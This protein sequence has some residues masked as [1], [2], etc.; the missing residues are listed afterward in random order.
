MKGLLRAPKPPAGAPP[1]API[2]TRDAAAKAESEKPGKTSDRGGDK[3]V[4]A[5][6]LPHDRWGQ[7][8][9]N[10]TV[11]EDFFDAHANGDSISAEAI[12]RN[13][14]SR[15]IKRS[16]LIFS[17]TNGN[18]RFE[19]REP[20]GRAR[21][22]G[23]PIIL[24]QELDL[25]QFRYAYVFPDDTGYRVLRREI[26]RRSGVGVSM[27]ADTKRVYINVGELR[28]VWAGCPLLKAESNAGASAGS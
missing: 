2:D 25:R 15:G 14:D 3:R 27:K 9:F 12:D 8:A 6:G 22:A 17:S 5:A 10:R 7:A 20:E 18:H 21:P 1:I 16:Q 11:A 28:R 4:L 26:G 13:G 19:L 23:T 24:V